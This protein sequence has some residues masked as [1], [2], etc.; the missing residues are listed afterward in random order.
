VQA[1]P[2][3]HGRPAQ[4]LLDDPYSSGVSRLVSAMDFACAARSGRRGRMPVCADL[5]RVRHHCNR[6]AW[7]GSRIRT[8]A[9]AALAVSPILPRRVG[10]GTACRQEQEPI[11]WESGANHPKGEGNSRTEAGFD[12][13]AAQAFTIEREVCLTTPDGDR[14][15][16]S[17]VR[18]ATPQRQE[19]FFA[20]NSQS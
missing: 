10:P 16:G 8:C 18:C 14:A 5:L 17:P 9:L 11:L 1:Q 15:V 20:R 2:T 6:N 12:A 3:L 7:P 19:K 13:S 4:R